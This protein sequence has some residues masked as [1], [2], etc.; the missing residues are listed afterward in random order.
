MPLPPLHLQPYH[1]LSRSIAQRLASLRRPIDPL[2][3]WQVEVIV[4]SSGVG[5]AI[6]G[7]LA[8]ILPGGVAALRLQTIETFA[9]RL[10]NEA[11]HY[12]RLATPA[13]RRLAMR[14]AARSVDHPMMEMRGTAAMLER[15]YRDV[16]D[17]GLTVAA[18]AARSRSE[19]VR[20]RERLRAILRAWEEYERLIT[21]LGA[22][23][24][25]DL[26]ASAARLI[27]AGASLPPQIVA[28]FYDMTGAQFALVETLRGVEKLDSIYIPMD[29]HR[30][31]NWAFATPLVQR[32]ASESEPRG[33]RPEA[34]ALP[35]R[36]PQSTISEHRTREE[37][38]RAVCT[39]IAE[40]LAGGAAA[41]AIGVVARSLEPYDVHLFERFAREHGFTFSTRTAVPLPAHRIGRGVT[42]LVRLRE[43]DFP[44]GDV[45]E[46]VRAGLQ[47]STRIH[48]DR[49][50]VETRRAYIAGGGSGALEH[51][52][53]KSPVLADY[54]ALV[55]ELE[56][57]TDRIDASSLS[58]LVERFRIRDASDLAAVQA[59]DEIAAMFVRA[60]AWSRPLDLH[61]VLDAIEQ[62]SLDAPPPAGDLPLVWLGDVMRLRG[63]TFDE[64][65]A[66]RMQD[67]VLPQRRTEDPLL[68]DSDRRQL[69]IREIGDGRDEETLLFELMRGST[70]THFSYASSDGFG[71]PLRPSQSLKAFAIEQEPERKAEIL[72]RFS[73]CVGRWSLVVGR[74]S[75]HDQRPTTNVQRALQLLTRSG[76]RSVFDGY[77]DTPLL[78]ERTRAALQS[79]SPTQLEDFGECP[80]KFLFKHILGVTEIDNPEREVQINHREKGTVDHSILERF[81]RQTS[82]TEIRES[83]GALPRL[84]ALL[85][86]RLEQVIDE[87]FDRLEEKIPAFNRAMRSMERRA[88]KRILRDFVAADL[89]D[90]LDRDLMPAHFEYRFGKKHRRDPD[91]PDPFIIESHGIPI[92]V[93]GTIDRIDTEPR[94]LSPEPRY[95][96]VDYKSGKAL[97]HQDL[98]AKIERGVRL[99]LPLY[100]MAVASFFGAPAASVSGTIKPLVR[101]DADPDKFAFDL[102]DSEARLRE[103]LDIFVAAITRGAFPAFPSDSDKDFQSCKYCPVSHSC[104]TRHDGDERRAALEARDPRTMLEGPA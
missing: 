59:L 23:D 79:I 85:T 69:G 34:H 3:L 95:R 17:G 83:A 60:A 84:S 4:A 28:G 43:R 12:P 13:E 92:R 57:L 89:A 42:M 45:L 82:A 19:P 99:Q 90:L 94:A 2:A 98:A 56:A 70:V 66:V 26:L 81:Y 62:A 104:R 102:G 20:N 96:I 103:T 54:V 47:T 11:G 75:S 41:T 6:A 10:L 53:Q 58:R 21:R 9:Q 25:A 14:T 91:H 77:V 27:A 93:E 50:D 29:P 37:E 5:R 44:R 65:F 64:L 33:P 101:G 88:T 22:I 32:L 24:P 16:R 61:A 15:S 100:A 52:A 49:A 7:Q 72:K 87:E 55:A 38:A 71:R 35:I 1:E 68:P 67:G 51:R 74:L 30:P 76:T 80:Q 63:R 39:A 40:R 46:L 8:A 18:T 97:R 36:K 31:Q 48:A 86:D 73:S 78:H